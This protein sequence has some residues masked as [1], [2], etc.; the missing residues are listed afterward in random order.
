MNRGRDSRQQGSI[1]LVLL[2]AIVVGGLLAVV[3]ADVST[4]QR[5]ARHDR[6]FNQAVQV[7]DAGIQDA[8]T[9]LAFLDPDDPSTPPIGA[10][11]TGSGTLDEYSSHTWT[12]RRVGRVRW[13]IRSEGTTGDSTRVLEAGISP[14]ELFAWGAFGDLRL[15]LRGG[16]L[17]DSYNAVSFGTGNGSV[18]SNHDVVLRGNATVDW[19]LRYNLAAGGGAYNNGGVVLGGVQT[20][21]DRADLPNIG[22][23]AYADGGECHGVSPTAYTGSPPL[24]RG[25]IYC[26]SNV[27]FPAGDHQLATNPDPDLNDEPTKI[28]IA[29]SGNLELRGQGNQRCGGV[30]CVNY[31]PP[32]P[33]AIDLE[34]YLASGEFLANNHTVIAAG[35]WAPTSN[36]SGPN[37]QGDIYGSIVCRTLDSK[38]GW[39]FH[40]DDRFSDAGAEDFRIDGIREEAPGTTSFAT[41]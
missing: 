37:A 7:A 28:F 11:V 25:T 19:V 18:G 23:Q 26:F 4:G 33:S 16:N 38:G 32:R 29:P 5:T 3:F 8:F 31:N 1:P 41:D 22:E 17:A 10:T 36:C 35:I 27:V 21:D 20:A 12:A 15:E 24:V 39:S 14:T 40:Y 6:D 13:Q 34:I 30:A 9:T 2:V